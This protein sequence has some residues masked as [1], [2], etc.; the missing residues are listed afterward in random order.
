MKNCHKLEESC[1]FC[2]TGIME[3]LYYAVPPHTW[4][5]LVG[6]GDTQEEIVYCPICGEKLPQYPNATPEQFSEWYKGYRCY[7]YKL[8]IERTS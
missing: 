3:G 4:I 7:P 5:W 8:K 1:P 6:T 2:K